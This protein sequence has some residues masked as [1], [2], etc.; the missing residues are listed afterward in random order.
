MASLARTSG[1]A[2]LIALSAW[3][4]PELVAAHVAWGNCIAKA[5]VF[6]TNDGMGR[7]ASFQKQIF[8]GSPSLRLP[9]PQNQLVR[10]CN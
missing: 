3:Y 4:D 5:L 2:S 6:P 1:R 9:I 7:H 10:C 8:L